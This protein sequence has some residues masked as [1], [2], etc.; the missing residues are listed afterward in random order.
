[1]NERVVELSSEFFGDERSELDCHELLVKDTVVADHLP[2]VLKVADI[3]LSVLG[4]NLWAFDL[5]WRLRRSL[6]LLT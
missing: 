6:D 2:G 3:T 5:L 4:A 1:M